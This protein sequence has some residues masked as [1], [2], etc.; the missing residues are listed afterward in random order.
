M[1]FDRV[2]KRMGMY[3]ILEEAR[4]SLVQ[5]MIKGKIFAVVLGDICVDMLGT[6][7]DDNQSEEDLPRALPH[8]RSMDPGI[9]LAYLPSEFLLEA[10]ELL[11]D[12]HWPERLYR[13]QDIALEYD[14]KPSMTHPN[15]KHYRVHDKFRVVVVTSLEKKQL[16]DAL[17]N[18]TVGLPDSNNFEIVTLGEDTSMPGIDDAEKIGTLKKATNAVMAIR[19]MGGGAQFHK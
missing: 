3:P 2:S 18:G 5:C 16:T 13:R 4:R 10:G 8:E 14:V 11:R 6:F 19:A 15:P 17:F 7:N 9:R 12:S 1:H